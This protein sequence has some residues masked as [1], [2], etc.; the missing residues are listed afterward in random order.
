MLD[1]MK[2]A[3]QGMMT[4]SARQDIITNN[5][6]NVGTAGY[7]KESISISSF[8]EILNRETGGMDGM[9]QSSCEIATPPGMEMSSKL[10]SSSVTHS[11]QGSLKETGNPFD[12]ALDD[13]GRGFFTI[14][15]PEGIKFTR[16]GSFRLST[17]GYLVT[18]DGSFVLGHR[19]PMKL[20]G[21]NFQVSNEGV[22]SV[23]GKPVDRLLVTVFDDTKQLK[24]AGDSNFVAEGGVRA[25]TDF[26][27][28]QGYVEQANVNS[29]NEMV[30]MMMVMRNYEAN[31]KVLQAHDQRLQ[32]TVNE[33]GR[34]R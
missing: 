7:R 23:D 26:Q 24:R 21:S 33:L 13:N 8:T 3:A 12:M 6:A 14:Q 4:Q 32:K 28:K 19:G 10:S 16:A 17:S 22:V 5:L 15:T 2:M 31:Q 30:D 27:L 20:N 25:T 11:S 1:G 9:H 34:V 18:N 29:I